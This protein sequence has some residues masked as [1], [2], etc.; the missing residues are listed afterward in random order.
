MQRIRVCADGQGIKVGR[1]TLWREVDRKVVLVGRGALP[2]QARDPEW[3]E[4]A[5]H[6]E[7]VEGLPS[8]HGAAAPRLTQGHEPVETAHRGRFV[9]P[10]H[11]N[12]GTCQFLDSVPEFCGRP[13]I[14]MQ[15]VVVS[16]KRR[17]AIRKLLAPTANP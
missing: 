11:E 16:A 1:G 7:Q 17:R 5:H 9:Q 12:S 14:Y 6:P 8:G 2:R 3:L 13:D 15:A 4:S 10:A